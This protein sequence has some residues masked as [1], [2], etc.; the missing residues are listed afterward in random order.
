M[1]SQDVQS[2]GECLQSASGQ[3][4]PFQDLG[5]VGDS[6]HIPGLAIIASYQFQ[7][8]GKITRWQTYVEPGGESENGN[9]TMLFVVLRPAPDVEHDGCYNYVGI[10]VREE[11]V[12]G[13][14]SLVNVTLEPVNF[15]IVQPGDVVGYGIGR[16]GS[17]DADVGILIQTRDENEGEEVW[18]SSGIV[19]L[20][21]TIDCLLTVGDSPG[22]DFMSF[23]NS[24]PALR[25]DVGKLQLKRGA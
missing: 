18:Y 10:D 20:S 9:Y 5:R 25:V 17:I 3:G 2:N 13:P 16:N 11:F 4:I 22:R 19:Q 15:I 12:L 8:C 1:L 21:A 7:C 23:S 6:E 14:D 24:A